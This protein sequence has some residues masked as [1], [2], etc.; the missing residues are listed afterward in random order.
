MHFADEVKAIW[1]I[2]AKSYIEFSNKDF[3]NVSH[4]MEAT[5]IVL[6]K[7]NMV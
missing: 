4:V 7:I 5:Y 6:L 2:V 1:N 3:K